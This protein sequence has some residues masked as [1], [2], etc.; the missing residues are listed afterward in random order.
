MLA[1]D[2]PEPLTFQPG[3]KPPSSKPPFTCSEADSE[4]GVDEDDHWEDDEWPAAFLLLL[5]TN[6]LLLLLLAAFLLL[7]LLL[8]LCERDEADAGKL[9]GCEDEMLSPGLLGLTLWGA[10]FAVELSVKPAPLLLDELLGCGREQT[11]RTPLLAL[12]RCT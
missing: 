11:T 1:T 3:T 7:L 9:R 12:K 2:S 4:E 10:A 8:E 6:F 5:V